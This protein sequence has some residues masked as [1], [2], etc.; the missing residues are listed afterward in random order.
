MHKERSPTEEQTIYLM[1]RN[2]S[3]LQAITLPTR[4]QHGES[5]SQF[6]LHNAFLR[7]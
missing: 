3:I 2:D 4:I 6:M 1:H 5:L 7:C